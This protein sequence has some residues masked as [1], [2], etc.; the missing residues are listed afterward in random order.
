[1]KRILSI[2]TA[3]IFGLGFFTA[4]AEAATVV[5]TS[6]LNVRQAPSTSSSILGKVTTGQT[7]QVTGKEND[8]LRILHNGQT[9]YVSAQYTKQ[10]TQY[11]NASVL[12][13][14]TGPGTNHSIVGKL[15]HGQAVQVL[16]DA[17]NGWALI[18]FDR[19]AAYVSKQFLGTGTVK[20][21]Q[22]IQVEAT[23]YTPYDEGMSGITAMGID[24]RQN[25]NMKL[26]AVDPKIIPLGTK[27]WVEGYGE[28]LAGDT[29]GAIKGNRIDVLMPT[30]E[31]AFQ[32]GRKQV[33]IRIAD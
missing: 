10:D 20:A 7:L 22:E 17:G 18:G 28:A 19:G 27:V 25:P 31:Q 2:T 6:V 32:W 12:N 8:W 33:K 9:A 5:N 23:A 26:I 29:G 13:V 1:M 30:K 16:S 14:R 11:V 4:A 24:V 21:A 15:I 3:A